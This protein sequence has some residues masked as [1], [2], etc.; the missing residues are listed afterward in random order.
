MRFKLDENL[1][2]KLIDA[3]RLAGHDAH[4]VHDERLDGHADEEVWQ[5]ALAENRIVI[6][7]DNDFGRLA[8]R[9]ESHSGAPIT[10]PGVP[11]REAITSLALRALEQ[12]CVGDWR[13]PLRIV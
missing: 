6:S 11:S 7:T 5:A 12:I 1:P 9:V 8:I 2:R 10:R 4:T 3:V 13:P